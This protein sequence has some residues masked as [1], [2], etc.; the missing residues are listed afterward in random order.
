MPFINIFKI[1]LHLLE[2]DL[3]T[4]SSAKSLLAYVINVSKKSASAS[5]LD[6]GVEASSSDMDMPT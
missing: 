2:C 3:S 1:F 5:S 6:V 4:I